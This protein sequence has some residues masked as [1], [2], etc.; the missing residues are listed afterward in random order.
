MA[1]LQAPRWDKLSGIITL[2]LGLLVLIVL[3]AGGNHGPGRH[4][5]S[6]G[7]GGPLASVA[8]PAHH[9]GEPWPCPRLGKLAL[10]THITASADGSAP[11]LPSSPSPWPA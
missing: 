11:S 2:T 4:P 3:L 10:T 8:T 6:P 5:S 1:R 7:H 9:R